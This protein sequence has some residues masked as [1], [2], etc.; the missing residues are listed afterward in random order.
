[1]IAPMSAVN[2]EQPLAN[3]TN[4]HVGIVHQ[5]LALDRL[6]ALLGTAAQARLIAAQALAFFNDVVREHHGQEERELF[7]AVLTSAVPGPERDGVQ[8][9][10]NRLTREHREVESAFAR[11]EGPL[12]A[13]AKGHEAD[14]DADAVAALVAGYIGH[15]GFE[16]QHFLPL[17]QVILSRKPNDLAALGLSL[18]LRQAL[19]EVLSRFG[20]RI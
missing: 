11:L 17:A 8:A 19:P 18:H 10:V 2:T 9:M 4:C 13:A 1:M 5:L 12:K 15:A 7:P 16:E 20:S 6:P 14:L 3:F